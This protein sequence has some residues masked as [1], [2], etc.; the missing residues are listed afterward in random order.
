MRGASAF[1]NIMQVAG[2]EILHSIEMSIS[3]AAFGA[4]FHFGNEFPAER[5]FMDS[6]FHDIVIGVQGSQFKFFLFFGFIQESH[7]I[8]GI[9]NI[10]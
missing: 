3:A 5:T 6:D 2:L 4:V 9:K 10:K 1:I 8:I 7:L